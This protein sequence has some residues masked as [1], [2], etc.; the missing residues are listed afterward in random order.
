MNK[1]IYYRFWKNLYLFSEEYL[2]YSAVLDDRS[3]RLLPRTPLV[4]EY[5]SMNWPEICKILITKY[6]SIV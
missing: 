3:L 1:I 6:T 4:Q 5:Q 2:L